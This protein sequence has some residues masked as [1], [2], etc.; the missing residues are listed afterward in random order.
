VSGYVHW[1]DASTL[2]LADD[3]DVTAWPDGGS[4]GGSAT[5]PS[6][7]RT[8]VYVAN[9]GTETGLGAVYFDGDGGAD[10]S[11]AL[12][13]T[14]D[15]E[16]RTVFSV[17]K[18]NAFLLTDF[19]TYN[20]HRPSDDN[21]ADP[22]IVD[23]DAAPIVAGQTYVNGVLVDP[24]N[25][26]MPTDVHNGFNLVEI[27]TDENPVNADSFNKDRTYHAGNQ[28][29]AEVIIYDRV[30]TEVE[31]LSVEQY[32]VDKWFNPGLSVNVTV[33]TNGSNY[34]VGATIP[35]TATELGSGV[36]LAA[37]VLAAGP[38]A[39]QVKTVWDAIKA[40]NDYFHDKV[41]E[42]V[43]RAGGVPEFMEIT[44]EQVE[45]KREAVFNERMGKMPE[46]F[47]AI[48]RALVMQAHQVE[49]VPI[50]N[51]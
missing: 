15:T 48:R 33:P 31:R 29:Q 30:L 1:F 35:A 38:I 40:K 37:A 27:L 7:N 22:L 34:L 25:D 44:P 23:Y 21:P 42:G 17:F 26:A 20:F 43:V 49:I 12:R 46:L 28:Y 11:M 50:L 36:N 47:D 19:D 24:E 39:D 16:I 5:V 8:P 41:F 3:A 51:P 4:S 45:A 32:L 6:G 18:G 10:G 9:A 14:R 13:F 2:G